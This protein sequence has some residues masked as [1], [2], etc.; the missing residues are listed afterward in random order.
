[1]GY[2]VDGI[3]GKEP[4]IGNIG[5]TN[6]Q[7][8]TT[9]DAFEEVKIHT[10]GTPA[11]YGHAAGGLMS[12][13]FKSGT[14]QFH[15]SVEDRYI[16]K[17]MIHRSYLE[18]LPRTNPFT[19]HETTFLFSGPVVSS[20]ALQREQQDVLAGRLGAALRERR[21]RGRAHERAYGSDVQ[22]RLFVRRSDHARVRCRFTIRSPLAWKGTTWVRDPFPGNIIPK[23]LFDPA[24]QKF[25][26][27]NPFASPNQAG[28]PA[29]SGP[30]ENLVENQI[31][32]IRRI[33]WDGKI[34]HQFTPNHRI[35]GRYSQ[36]RHRAW[37]GDYQAQFAWRDLDPN[38][39]HAPVDHYNGVISDMLILSPT[40]SN[41]FR[42]GYNRRERYE[43]ALT[44]N[45]DWGTSTGHSRESTARRSR[46]SISA[47]RFPD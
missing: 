16:G 6:E 18:Q 39:Q 32:Q 44:A 10:T 40:L 25:L 31:K 24:V 41:E 13:V 27:L 37:K 19:Y 26:A 33:R 2:T 3:N 36:A 34:D 35:F 43:T 12:I 45:G 15:G 11:E 38:A 22:R 29:R 21:Y 20:E 47:A 46:T 42:A 17:S 23:N 4:G 5:G 1:M 28:I 7:I 8:S 9:Q 14:N 30:T